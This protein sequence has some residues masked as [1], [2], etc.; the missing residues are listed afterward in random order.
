MFK[1]TIERG[2]EY[3]DA[4]S[5]FFFAFATIVLASPLLLASG[6]ASHW[7]DY[8]VSLLG[9]AVWAGIIYAVAVIVG[10]A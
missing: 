10:V 9:F 6:G 8:V 5:A 4:V 2:Q 3:A 1:D 7:S